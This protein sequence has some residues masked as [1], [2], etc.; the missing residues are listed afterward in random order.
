MVAL[1]KTQI[2]LKCWSPKRL[3]AEDVVNMILGFGIH[4]NDAL[5]EEK[6]DNNV[7][8]WEIKIEV[9]RVGGAEIWP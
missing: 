9:R 7:V 4:H 1:E 8:K 6:Y 3:T 2:T 5:I